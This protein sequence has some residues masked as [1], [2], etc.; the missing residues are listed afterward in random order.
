MEEKATREEYAEAFG[1]TPEEC[2]PAPVETETGGDTD[3]KNRENNV[4]E[5]KSDGSAVEGAQETISEEDKE[6]GAEGGEELQPGAMSPEERH[7]QAAARRAREQQEAQQRRMQEQ[8]GRDSLVAEFFK[9]QTSPFTGKPVTT[10]AEYRAY[11]AQ[12]DAEAANQQLQRAG[13]TPDTIQGIVD[14]QLAP[15]KQQLMQ[16][17][18][19]AAQERARVVNA[20]A[21]EAIG[22]ALKA[23]SAEMPEI[24]SM[25]D[26]AAMPTSGEF[27]RLVQQG[28]RID[29]A[30]YLANRKEIE[31]RKIAA[32]KASAQR[33]AAG[34]NHLDPVPSGGGSAPVEVPAAMQAAY[35]EMMPDAT[36]AEI[37]AA[38]TKYLKD[39]K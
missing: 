12:R 16:E 27:N 7:R 30:F 25:E 1:L 22:A 4:G 20:Q 6:D 13:I 2:G 15:I 17:Q 37:K 3:P 35:R 39:M 26:I 14:Q 38:Y 33:G 8:Q 9:G 5:G 32:A 29:E 31:S 11:I 19:R 21:Q 10:E 36:D 34:K 24:K 18:M 23:I 28:I